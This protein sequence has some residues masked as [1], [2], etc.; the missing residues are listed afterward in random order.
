M[1]IGMG[2]R[3]L[4]RTGLGI[5]IITLAVLFAVGST[6]AE[7][8]EVWTGPDLTFTKAN[9][10]DWTKKENQDRITSNVWITRESNG[11]IFNIKVESGG[12]ANCLTTRPAD[13][14][15]AT[16]SAADWESLSF[17]PFLAWTGCGP[18]NVI[19][20]DAVVHLI[21]DDIYIDIRLTSWTGMGN[22]G[23]S[24]VRSTPPPDLPAA[25][26]WWMLVLALFLSLTGMA[27]VA[28]PSVYTIPDL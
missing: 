26:G 8:Q 27:F 22:G 19:G 16:G 7:A 20:V 1:G 11:P 10:A 23:F 4:G 6:V 12:G 28:H 25:S 5:R 18:G 3:L 13:T 24:Y 14:E 2:M 15:W 9:G 21:T 17:Q